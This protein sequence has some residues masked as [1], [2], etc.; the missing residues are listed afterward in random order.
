MDGCDRKHGS[1][2]RDRSS[3]PRLLAFESRGGKEEAKRNQRGT[4]E[5]AMRRN[6]IENL[7][8]HAD[9][10][11]PSQRF[12]RFV[13]VRRDNPGTKCCSSQ[14]FPGSSQRFPRL[15]TARRDNPG[16]KCCSSRPFPRFVTAVSAVRH[17]QY[18][19]KKRPPAGRPLSTNI[20][21]VH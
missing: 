14:P 3:L 20:F 8:R 18:P 7:V 4:K 6:R 21:G 13:T 2:S 19:K 5:E 16:K 11:G 17:S 12:P 1:F 10:Y 15:V 9:W